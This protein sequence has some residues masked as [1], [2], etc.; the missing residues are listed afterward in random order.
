ML[1]EIWVEERVGREKEREV[2]RAEGESDATVFCR[3]SPPLLL[4]CEEKAELSILREE[5]TSCSSRLP[6]NVYSGGP[7]RRPTRSRSPASFSS[8]PRLAKPPPP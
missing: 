8:L 5:A 4:Y 3:C 7:E 1:Y 2:G 6:L